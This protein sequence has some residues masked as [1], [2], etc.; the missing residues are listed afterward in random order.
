MT[1][2]LVL[3]HYK[4]YSCVLNL[5]F[6]AGNKDNGQAGRSISMDTEIIGEF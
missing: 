1:V 5:L 4:L 3:V 2:I 6:F